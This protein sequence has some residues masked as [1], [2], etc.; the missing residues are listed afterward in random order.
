MEQDV[1]QKYSRPEEHS[2]KN[3]IQ[4]AVTRNSTLA[5][6]AASIDPYFCL[7]AYDAA[8]R[9]EYCQLDAELAAIPGA[10]QAATADLMSILPSSE[11]HILSDYFFCVR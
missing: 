11:K 1:P 5:G 2:A 4:R 9:G 7:F 6:E 3:N 10:A 8:A